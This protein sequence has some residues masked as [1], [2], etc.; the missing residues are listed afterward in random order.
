MGQRYQLSLLPEFERIWGKLSP[1]V[2][3]RGPYRKRTAAEKESKTVERLTSTVDQQFSSSHGTLMRL[4]SGN[5]I[6]VE[7][8]ELYDYVEH[9]VATPKMRAFLRNNEMLEGRQKLQ[10]KVDYGA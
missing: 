6:L 2:K 10:N 8:K 1:P 5:L 7:W 9:K 4:P 3:K